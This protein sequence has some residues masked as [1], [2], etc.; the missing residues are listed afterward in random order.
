M[1][2][3]PKLI[4]PYKS[5][6]VK[7]YQ[8]WLIGDDAFADIFNA[9]VWRG[10]VR[11]R[12]GY[13]FFSTLPTTPV[14][15][16]KTW[17]N[18]TSFASTSVALSTT[19]AYYYKTSTPAYQDISFYAK[20]AGTAFS[21]SGATTDFFWDCNFAASLWVT[22]NVLADG[23]KFW[24][25]IPGSVGVSGGWSTHAPTV[26]GSTQLNTATI[27]LPYKGRL[28]TLNTTEGGN[29]FPQRARWCQIGSPYS[30]NATAVS[31]SNITAGNPTVVF[32][33]NTS[34]F[35]LGT[36][37]GILGVV[38]SIGA[39]LNT[40]QF[41]VSSITA[42]TK[43]SIDVDTT[44][45]S[46]TSGGTAQGIGTTVPPSNFPITIFGWRDD[47][48]GY[49]GFVDADTSERIVS[50]AIV[51]DVLVVNFQRST[52]RLRYTGNEILPFIWERINTQYG[53]ESTFAAI[54]FD[55]C[56]LNFSRYGWIAADTQQVTRID[57]Q[58]PDNSFSVDAQSQALTG[59]S[60]VQGIRDYYRQFAYWTFPNQILDVNNPTTDQ[61][62]AYNYIDKSWTIFNPNAD[63][64]C[65]GTYLENQSNTWSTFNT[66]GVD[67]WIDFSSSDKKWSLL[68]SA[69]NIAF[70]T[71]LG[72]DSSGNIYEM[73][74]FQQ[75]PDT[76]NEIN[77][78][79]SITT[80]RFN[81][82]ITEGLKCRVGYV[83]IYCTTE[84]GCEITFS[85]FVDDQLTP[86][87]QRTVVLNKRLVVNVLNIIPGYP[88]VIQLSGLSLLQPGQLITIV[89]AVG[90]IA[91][92]INNQVLPVT[93]IDDTSFSVDLD[94]TDFTYSGGANILT[95][96]APNS[97]QLS[98]VRVYLGAIAHMHQFQL[99]L[100][101]SQI[102]D[103]VIGSA[104][105][106]L[107]GM[108][109]WTRRAGRIRG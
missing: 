65:F 92:I 78:G 68:G 73:F 79:F 76:D 74:E 5:A 100:N 19:K 50:A 83:D 13:S 49:G 40:N 67:R 69:Q 94:T 37:A 31:I 25:G 70:P 22:N 11:K 30:S 55:D 103:P 45:L 84:V 54:P 97:G 36:P 91:P 26:N 102:S 99:S 81:P 85:H 109:L 1:G 106:E 3:E 12:E 7:Y 17:M 32:I 9:Y 88:T 38:G 4:A 64:R 39:V 8:P 15:G 23:I 44:G 105:F 52:W 51:K 77:L 21:W 90:T 93:I 20:P 42:N 24:T 87:V 107:Q 60:Y 59:L 101:Q 28:L 86:V 43:I 71:I 62:Y 46:Y 63:I 35:A 96:L 108:L 72:G 89:N 27:V 6:L 47:I 61:I 10:A 56:A 82:Y 29:F 75:S 104:Q 53:S 34:G 58:I 41:N 14:Q 2:Y 98:Y 16:I 33:N 48:P 57:Q 95:G 18:P 66:A 80:K